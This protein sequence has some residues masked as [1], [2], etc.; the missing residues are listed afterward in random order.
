MHISSIYIGSTY[1]PANREV[2]LPGRRG[3]GL[4][5]P[6]VSEGLGAELTSSVLVDR[7]RGVNAALGQA[8]RGRFGVN[9]GG[10]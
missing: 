10:G 4:S 3:D 1:F 8:R 9:L 6:S 5:R 2:P 7:G